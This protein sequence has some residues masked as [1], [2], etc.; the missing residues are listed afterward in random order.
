MQMH[1]AV[2][3]GTP[4]N[5]RLSALGTSHGSTCSTFSRWEYQLSTVRLVIFWRKRENL[6]FMSVSLIFKKIKSIIGLSGA[7]CQP[8][9]ESIRI[10]HN[11]KKSSM[12][13]VMY[14][15]TSFLRWTGGRNTIHVV[16]FKDRWLREGLPCHVELNAMRGRSFLVLRTWK[17]SKMDF[18]FL[19]L[20][21]PL[22]LLM[23]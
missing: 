21:L 3:W 19:L 18:S 16:L 7:S 14:M 8:L 23:K 17:R 15:N 20:P 12:V 4:Q 6:I 10:L 5:W 22:L 1:K 13:V 9:P 2:R 11:T